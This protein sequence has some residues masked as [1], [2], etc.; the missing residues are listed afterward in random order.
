MGSVSA[1]VG[2]AFLFEASDKLT[3]ELYP[4]L[5]LEKSPETPLIGKGAILD[6]IGLIDFLT[7]VEEIVQ[8][9]TG[10]SIRILSEKAMSYTQSPLK[11]FST[12]A[13]YVETL[14]AEGP[15]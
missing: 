10:V 14:I 7:L 2:L 5:K 3:T 6:S 1:G 12:L 8:T 15:V 13:R 11:D 9:K 4:E